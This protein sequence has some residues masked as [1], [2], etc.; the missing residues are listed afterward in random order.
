MNLFMGHLAYDGWPD[1]IFSTAH[2]EAFS[3]SLGQ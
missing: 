3:H 2:G 1:F